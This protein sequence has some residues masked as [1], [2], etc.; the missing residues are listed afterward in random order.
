M[1]DNS[2]AFVTPV[3]YNNKKKTFESYFVDEIEG[4]KRYEAL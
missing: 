2:S 1:N 4:K 3:F